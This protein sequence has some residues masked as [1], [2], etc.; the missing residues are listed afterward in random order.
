MKAYE[1][2]ELDKPK[3]NVNLGDPQASLEMQ[4][5]QESASVSVDMLMDVD[6]ESETKSKWSGSL[7]EVQCSAMLYVFSP[8]LP[9]VY[10]P[11]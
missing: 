6:G 11:R 3:N 2:P 5:K 9:F 7:M 10:F 1:D 8:H 4:M